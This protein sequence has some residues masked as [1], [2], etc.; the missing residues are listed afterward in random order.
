[1]N[2]K[3]TKEECKKEAENLT[4]D[5][6]SNW[7]KWEILKEMINEMSMRKVRETEII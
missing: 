3:N 7:S 2:E 6:K 5:R 4:R 1:M